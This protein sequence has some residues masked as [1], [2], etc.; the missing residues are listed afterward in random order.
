MDCVGH[1]VAIKKCG[2]ITRV[3]ADATVF[4]IVLLLITVLLVLLLKVFLVETCV[5]QIESVL[6]IVLDKMLAESGRWEDFGEC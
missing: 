1:F 3:A 4:L 2:G 5:L 6:G